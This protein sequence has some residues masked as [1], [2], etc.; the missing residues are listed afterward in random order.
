MSDDGAYGGPSIGPT[1][2]QPPP[3][4]PAADEAGTAIGWDLIGLVP[5][6]SLLSAGVDVAEGV[7]SA[8]TGD[9]TGA[10]HH[11]EDAALDGIGAVPI[12]GTVLGME[13]TAWDMN[14]E[15]NREHGASAADAPTFSQ[16]WEQ[17]TEGIVNDFLDPTSFYPE[18][19]AE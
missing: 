14:A 17:G 10:L 16:A 5:G 7:G 18:G 6:G 19:P 13:A 4:N 2:D 11:A 3:S 15:S 9:G 12:A 1:P 8:V